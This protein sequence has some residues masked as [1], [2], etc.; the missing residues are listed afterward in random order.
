M[1]LPRMTKEEKLA[2][3]RALQT[4]NEGSEY[5]GFDHH[6]GRRGPYVVTEYRCPT[7]AEFPGYTALGAG[8]VIASFA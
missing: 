1:A 5:P 7:M 8:P 4:S 2:V 6:A 3:I